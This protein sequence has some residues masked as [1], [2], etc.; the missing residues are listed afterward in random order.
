MLSDLDSSLLFKSVV[1]T[2]SFTITYSETLYIEHLLEPLKILSNLDAGGFQIVVCRLVSR[3]RERQTCVW[4]R[5]EP[6]RGRRQEGQLFTCDFTPGHSPRATWKIQAGVERIL[7]PLQLSGTMRTPWKEVTLTATFLSTAPQPHL[8][9]HETQV[10]TPAL[11]PRIKGCLSPDRNGSEEN[12]HAVYTG[13]YRITWAANKHAKRGSITL[14]NTVPH[15][16]SSSLHY[17]I[18]NSASQLSLNHQY[19]VHTL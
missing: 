7:Q 15:S 4:M 11:F 3:G 12:I 13:L 17:I 19:L 9:Y 6:G 2:V 16:V 1:A 10:Q 8:P 18:L 5:L 14:L